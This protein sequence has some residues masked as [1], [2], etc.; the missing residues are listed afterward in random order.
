MAN[1][2]TN[3]PVADGGD[4][5]VSRDWNWHPDLPLV[6]P[7]LFDWPPSFGAIFQ[8]L[9]LRWLGF[10]PNVIWLALAFA[11]WAW[12]L[13][14]SSAM[15]QFEFGWMAQIYA[16]NFV[17]LCLVAGGL[18]I[19]FYGA[20]KQG[21]RRKFE[22]RDM[23]RNNRMFT[24]S[25]QVKDNMF[26]SLVSGVGFW[27]AY[28]IIYFWALA[29]GYAPGLTFADNPVWFILMFPIVMLWS[30]LHFYWVHRLLHWPPL[31]RTAHRLHHR[32]INIGPWSGISMHP[33]EHLIY[34]TN[35]A[36]HFVVASHPVHVLFHMLF[37]GLGPAPSHSGFETLLI[38]DKSR[39]SLGDFF[40][41]L[42]HRYFECNYGTSDMPWDR[43]FGSFHDGTAEATMH[44]RK[45][46]TEMEEPA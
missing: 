12:F 32:N 37:Q 10:T 16:K 26:W 23:A 15:K 43:W 45:R 2:K 33:V 22:R 34:F 13:P 24:F 39:L 4:G 46:I 44:V 3:A 18:H 1:S 25:D 38:R 9:F 6:R 29:N 11:L 8:W 27:S 31:Y 20:R 17:L 30:S 35:I 5:P 21:T 42:H 36:I 40:H 41:Q 7:T 19:Y 28:E 14:E